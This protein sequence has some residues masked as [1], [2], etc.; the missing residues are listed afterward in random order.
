[1][2]DNYIE[3]KEIKEFKEFK[4]PLYLKLVP[5]VPYRLRI[6][7]P[8]PFK[9]YKHYVAFQRASVLCL[10]D[11]CPICDRNKKLADENKGVPYAQIKGIIPRQE[12]YVTNVLNRTLVK[13]TSSG[14]VVY[15][16][17]EDEFPAID[18]QSGEI[19][20]NIEPTPLNTVEVL[21]KGYEFFMELNILHKSFRNAENKL[22][23]LT[24]FDLRV[25]FAGGKNKPSVMPLPIFDE[26]KVPEDQM[27]E[28]STLGI[29]LTPDEITKLLGGISLRDIFAIRR[30]SD[31]KAVQVEQEVALTDVSNDVKKLFDDSLG[32]E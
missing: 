9:T 7:N 16:N 15:A 23:G 27:F 11:N 10:G 13:R 28:L 8:K 12:R 6:L 5:G 29:L 21:E 1:M 2:I 26:V 22:P 31:E 18:S 4:K 24:G 19:I 25:Y 17:L 30:Q 32:D 3:E 14:S 20:A